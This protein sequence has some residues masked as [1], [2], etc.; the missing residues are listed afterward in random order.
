MQ[1]PPWRLDKLSFQEL[2]LSP[3][4]VSSLQ[5]FEDVVSRG[6]FRRALTLGMDIG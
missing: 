1:L 5:C 2:I 4:P 6:L 3:P